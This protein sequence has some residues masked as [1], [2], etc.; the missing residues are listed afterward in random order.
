MVFVYSAR[1]RRLIVTRPGSGGP[2]RSAWPS[3]ASSQAVTASYSSSFGRRAVLGRHLAGAEH[4]EHLA[5]R[6]PILRHG[7]GRAVLV[8]LDASFGIG[9][10]MAIQ[11]IPLD[12]RQHGGVEGLRRR[13]RRLGGL[14]GE[15]HRPQPPHKT[16]RATT[17]HRRTCIVSVSLGQEGQEPWAGRG[18][19]C[20]SVGSYSLYAGRPEGNG[21]YSVQPVRY[22]GLMCLSASGQLGKR[23]FSASYSSFMPAIL[24]AIT[25]NMASSESGPP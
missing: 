19:R 13:G 4:V 15:N 18:Q 17:D 9:P 6:R 22:G 14:G 7:R 3:V 8:Q 12:E 24:M 25:P 21:A 10:A 11:A 20:E 1:L 5:P 16:L 2:A 23:V